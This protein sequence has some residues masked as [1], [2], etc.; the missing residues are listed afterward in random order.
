MD[1]GEQQMAQQIKHAFII[2]SAINTKFGVFSPRERLDQTLNTIATVKEQVPDALIVVMEVCGQ[3]INDLQANQIKDVCDVFIDCSNDEDVQALYDNDNW[4]VVKNATEIMCFSRVLG[5]LQQE[6]LLLGVDRVHKLSGRYLL[7]NDFDLAL[8][9]KA[10]FK[11]KII[12]GPK[13][14]SQFPIEMTTVPLQYMARLWSWPHS[15]TDDIIKVYT[16]SFKFFAERV[17]ANGYVDIEH[18]LYKFLPAEL[19]HEEPKL[20]VEGE[21]APNG[22]RIYN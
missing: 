18:V 11:D 8:Y 20:G 17:A 10:E 16:D 3:P 13:H 5:I 22:Q 6:K 15:M 9:N 1:L 14:Q 7:N 21:I 12:I 2:T 19:V 4:D